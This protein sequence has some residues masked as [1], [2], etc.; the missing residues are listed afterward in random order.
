[1]QHGEPQLTQ[2]NGEHKVSFDA[3]R[4]TVGTSRCIILCIF[5]FHIY[6]VIAG[7]GI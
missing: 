7:A 2:R 4:I 3:L 6:L 1:M 5:K